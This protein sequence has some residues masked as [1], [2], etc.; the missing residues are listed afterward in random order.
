[1]SRK[2]ERHI[3]QQITIIHDGIRIHKLCVCVCE[4]VCVCVC[5][6]VCA[7]RAWRIESLRHLEALYEDFTEELTFLIPFSSL[8]RNFTVKKRTSSMDYKSVGNV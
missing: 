1:M 7:L 6:C 3:N 4:C 8:T 5:V 2:R